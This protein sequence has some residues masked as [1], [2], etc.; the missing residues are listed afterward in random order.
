MRKAF[1]VSVV[2]LCGVMLAMGPMGC[3]GISTSATPAAQFASLGAAGTPLSP[4]VQLARLS[5]GDRIAVHKAA[6]SN[7]QVTVSSG[8]VNAYLWSWPVSGANR[9]ITSAPAGYLA[10]DLAANHQVLVLSAY[11]NGY[12]QL[13]TVPIPAAGQ[14]ITQITQITTD[15]QNHWNPHISPDGSQVAFVLKPG[16]R[17]Q[18]CLIGA[19][20]GDQ[21]CLSGLAGPNILH[22]SWTP[23]GKIAFE[24]WGTLNS[25][26]I[27]KDE[28]YIVNI[29]GSNLTQITNNGSGSSY[30]EAPSVSSD[31][32]KMVVCTLGGSSG[33]AEISVIDLATKLKTQV[34]DGTVTGGDSYDPLFVGTNQIVY[35]SKHSSDT[36]FE[37]YTMSADGSNPTEI[38]TTSYDNYFDW[39]LY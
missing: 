31:G 23:D 10:V 34:T 22:P 6:T 5:M 3:G 1:P 25:S 26:G 37:L 35:V 39:D 33:Y 15:L 18:L 12:M 9:L 27:Y 24:A 32:T 17:D 36:N 30:D 38:T 7:A 2:L 29:D 4:A 13:F 14:R 16:T 20:G 11:S 8:S 19:S 21:N 28:I